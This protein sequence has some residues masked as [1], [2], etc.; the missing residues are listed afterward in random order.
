M[1]ITHIHADAL[2]N[3]RTG[4]AC[5]CIVDFTPI[6]ILDDKKTIT[7]LQVLQDVSLVGDVIN[8]I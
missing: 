4:A 5:M 6:A 2:F 8:T 3:G 7:T 1:K